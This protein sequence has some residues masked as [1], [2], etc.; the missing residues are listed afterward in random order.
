MKKSHPSK[1]EHVQALWQSQN[2][3]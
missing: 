2:A 3:F 1:P